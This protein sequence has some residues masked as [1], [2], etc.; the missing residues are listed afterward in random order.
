MTTL[1]IMLFDEHQLAPSFGYFFNPKWVS[2]YE[3]IV[4]MLWKFERA[5]ALAGHVLIT[6]FAKDTNDSSEGIGGCPSEVTLGKVQRLLGIPLRIVRASLFQ[7]H[8]QGQAVHGSGIADHA[9]RAATMT[10]SISCEG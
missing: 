5:N 9:G 10:S 3:S 4:S 8:W 2:P 1:P 6:Q 7:N